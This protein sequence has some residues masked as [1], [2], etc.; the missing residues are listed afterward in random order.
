MEWGA[1]TLVY[2][3]QEKGIDSDG[4]AVG[5]E[6]VPTSSEYYFEAYP[7]LRNRYEYNDTIGE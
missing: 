6:N 7:L 5:F 2:Q 1:E 3:Q 4:N